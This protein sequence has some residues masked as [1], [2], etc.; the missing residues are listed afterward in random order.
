M[1]QPL[2]SVSIRVYEGRP[3]VYGTNFDWDENG[4]LNPT[5]IQNPGVVEELRKS[6]G[7]PSLVQDIQEKR[8][9]MA[10]SNEK[11]PEEIAADRRQAEERYKSVGWRK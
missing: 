10:S 11:P 4:E 1:L 3:Q 2:P 6:V 5:P 9:R 7:L 8:M